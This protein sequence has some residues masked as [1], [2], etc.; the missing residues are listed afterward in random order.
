MLSSASFW[1]PR[2][3]TLDLH[4]A[5]RALSNRLA[6]Q[7]FGT[8]ELNFEDQL[9]IDVRAQSDAESAIYSGSL[10]VLNALRPE[11]LSV[12]TLRP[13][14]SLLLVRCILSLAEKYDQKA[15][16]YALQAISTEATGFLNMI[17]RGQP[18]DSP[19]TARE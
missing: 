7:I 19:W 1:L 4:P 3:S 13:R 12:I 10:W 2:H 5:V 11:I 18:V 9:A 15:V 8:A 17:A 14:M 16:A 6:L